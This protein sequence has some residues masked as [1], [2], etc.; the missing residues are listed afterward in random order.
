M[1]I[2]VSLVLTQTLTALTP[3]FGS[4]SPSDCGLK[5]VVLVLSIYRRRHISWKTAD[6]K[7]LRWSEFIC[8]GTDSKTRHKLLS[9]DLCRC[10][11]GFHLEVIA[12]NPDVAAPAV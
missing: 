11:G 6:S 8:L 2:S 7:F 4:I 3:W 1:F 12:D 10:N 9:H 5:G